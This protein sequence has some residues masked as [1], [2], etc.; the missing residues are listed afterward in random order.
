MYKYARSVPKL[1]QPAFHRCPSCS[2]NIKKYTGAPTKYNRIKQQVA[3]ERIRPGQHLHMSFGV[4]RGSVFK[5]KN[6]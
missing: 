5:D 2:V 4:V 1:K 3:E 6:D